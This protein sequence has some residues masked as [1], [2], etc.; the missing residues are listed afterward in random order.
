MHISLK[1]THS[2]S[3]TLNVIFDESKGLNPCKRG[4]N[5]SNCLSCLRKLRIG[6][7]PKVMSSL[8]GRSC[9]QELPCPLALFSSQI[10]LQQKVYMEKSF[11]DRELIVLASV[12]ALLSF[13]YCNPWIFW[14]SVISLHVHL[15]QNENIISSQISF[16]ANFR[17]N[18]TTG[19][20]CDI[21]YHVIL[22]IKHSL[23]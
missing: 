12:W 3:L 14:S 22:P 20:F 1:Q 7:W 8:V 18:P 9:C 10:F 13:A 11:W 17:C 4:R 15:L 21:Q 5:H 16:W 19:I 2:I 23:E 6:Q